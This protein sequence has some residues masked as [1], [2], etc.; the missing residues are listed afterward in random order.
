MILTGVYW[1]LPGF[2]GFYLV[3]LGL[4]GFDWLLLGFT[5]FYW[6]LPSITGVLSCFTGFFIGFLTSFTRFL[7]GPYLILLDLVAFY[8][9]LLG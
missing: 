1:V 2:I 6:V 4:T 3:L 9:V 5:E 8:L 7:L